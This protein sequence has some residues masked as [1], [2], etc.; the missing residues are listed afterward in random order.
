VGRSD[1]TTAPHPAPPPR[2]LA[3]GTAIGTATVFHCHGERGRSFQAWSDAV[4]SEIRQVD[5]ASSLLSPS[6]PP[7]RIRGVAAI[8]AF[9]VVSAARP[10]V[11][12]TALLLLVSVIESAKVIIDAR[13]W[14]HRPSS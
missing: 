3:V 6:S 9:G 5:T 8:D 11:G 14:Q 10:A 13:I 4:A 1:K 12:A 2:S 7:P